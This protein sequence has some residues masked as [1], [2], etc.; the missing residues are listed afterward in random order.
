[1]PGRIIERVYHHDGKI[2]PCAL[3]SEAQTTTFELNFSLIQFRV[4]PL[5]HN[6][7]GYY[8]PRNRSPLPLLV[9]VEI[10]LD[11]CLRRE[12]EMPFARQN[13]AAGF[14]LC[15]LPFQD[16]GVCALEGA[17]ALGRLEQRYN[18]VLFALE[19]LNQQ[20]LDALLVP[21]EGD[22]PEPRHDGDEVGVV[23]MSD[24]IRLYTLSVDRAFDDERSRP[25][26]EGIK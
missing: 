10:E 3:F 4:N 5:D 6:V 12:A 20:L 9:L 7:S 24:A 2:F 25:P 16:C 15:A 17:N 22:P 14:S 18:L 8:D 23:P 21:A 1:M 19:L 11:G 13:A 26:Q